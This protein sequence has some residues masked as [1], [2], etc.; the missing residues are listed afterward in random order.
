[1]VLVAPVAMNICCF[2]YGPTDADAAALDAVNDEI[3]VQLQIQGIAAPSTTVVHGRTA[4]RV[5][6]TNHRT[7]HADLDWLVHEV[8]R[9]GQALLVGQ[10]PG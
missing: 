3:V 10:A 8:H 1:M 7:T 2:R 5:N 9:I 4:I 6:I